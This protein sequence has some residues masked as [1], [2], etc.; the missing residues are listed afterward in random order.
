MPGEA[1]ACDR[2]GEELRGAERVSYR[3]EALLGT[4]V[5]ETAISRRALLEGVV[6]TTVLVER[7]ILV[8]E[9]EPLISLDITAR[10]QEAG[11]RVLSASY[12]EKALGQTV[13]V[14]NRRGCAG[15]RSGRGG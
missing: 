5:P 9:D 15:F 11:A 6:E 12:L 7:C 3:G 13:I 8:V 1:D 14:D 2:R 4:A 10:L